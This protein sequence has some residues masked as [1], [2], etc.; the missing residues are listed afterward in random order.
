[1]LK[2]HTSDNAFFI[3]MEFFIQSNDHI[4]GQFL[5]GSGGLTLILYGIK[6]KP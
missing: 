6:D 4:S 1:M 3:L 5:G 2:E